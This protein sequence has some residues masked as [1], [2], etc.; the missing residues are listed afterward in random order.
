[1]AAPAID[2]REWSATVALLKQYELHQRPEVAVLLGMTDPARPTPGNLARWGELRE[3]ASAAAAFHEEH[4]LLVAPPGTLDRDVFSLDARQVADG[5]AITLPKSRVAQHLGIFGRSGEGKTTIAQR[6]AM[7]AYDR[8][9]GVITIDAKHDAQHLALHYPQTVVITPTTPIPFLEQP[10][11]LS[12]HE[13]RALLVRAVRRVWWG[14][15]GLDQVAHASLQRTREKYEHPSVHDWQRETLA[16]HEKGETYNQRDR[17]DGLASRLTRLADAYPGIG[18]TRAGGG[19]SLDD[20]CTRPIYFGYTI[21]T[22]AEELIATWLIELRFSYNRIHGIRTLNTVA[23]LDESLLLFHEDTISGNAAL[24]STFP[25]LREFGIAA[26]VTANHYRSLPASVRANLATHIVMNLSDSGDARELSQTLGLS[27]EQQEWLGGHLTLGQCVIKLPTWHHAIL[28]TFDP[29]TIEKSVPSAAWQTAIERTNALAR[30]EHTAAAKEGLTG[31]QPALPAPPREV[32][33]AEIPYNT[34]ALNTSEETLLRFIGEHRVVLT[35]ECD[36]HPQLLIRAK[37]KLLT[38]GLITE[39]KITA[40]AGRGGQ[41]NALGLTAAGAAWL[42]LTPGG[43]GGGGL[44]HQYLV[45]KL[46]ERIT[47]AQREVSLN[48]KRVDILFAYTA[49]HAGI[50]TASKIAPNAGDP[51]AIEVEVS[52]PAKTAPSNIEKNRAAGV[53]H[54]IVAVLPQQ[55][56]RTRAALAGATVVNIFDLV[57][58][59]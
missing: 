36:L 52:D 53:R 12:A 1:M 32:S 25:L 21:Q 23:L 18:A 22:A 24:G 19:I 3:I 4:P 46:I 10:S 11:W 7:S 47:G 38:L 27:R 56:E 54:T 33:A 9:L 8:D 30:P 37:K 13:A 58:R 59:V 45:R 16:L 50:A 28:A 14:G 20:L 42:R 48:G 35:T 6:L 49:A 55:L 41:A 51:V 34:I 44:Q 5:Q 15:E 31:Q 39:E 40:R 57:E 17:I 2:P 29:L 43:A 26:V